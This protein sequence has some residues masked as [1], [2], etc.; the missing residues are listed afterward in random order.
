MGYLKLCVAGSGGWLIDLGVF[1]GKN[2]DFF[3]SVIPSRWPAYS[4]NV[5][6][7]KEKQ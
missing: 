2:R 3:I 7:M 6:S 5:G 1:Q 4:I